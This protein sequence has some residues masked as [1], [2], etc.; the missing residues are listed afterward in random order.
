M[1]AWLQMLTAPRANAMMTENPDIKPQPVVAPIQK[2]A[3]PQ[4]KSYLPPGS[5]FAS[6]E[7]S[8]ANQTK[9]NIANGTGVYSQMAKQQA[10]VGQSLGMTKIPDPVVQPTPTNQPP[11]D[12][13]LSVSE[14]TSIPSGGMMSSPKNYQQQI[15]AALMKSM[16]KQQENADRAQ[17]EY[18]QVGEQPRGLA[19]VD[20]SP[21]LAMADQ[22]NGTNLSSVYKAP[23]GKTDH[24]KKKAALQAALEK[25]DGTVT[26]SQ[27]AYLKMKV[28]EE[29][30]RESAKMRMTL[31]GAKPSEFEKYQQQGMGKAAAEYFTQGRGQLE[32]NSQKIGDASNLIQEAINTKSPLFGA[33]RG[34]APDG[35]RAFTNP[36]AVEVKQAI[37]SAVTDTLKPTLG[38]QFTEG[39]GKRIMALQIDDRLSDEENLRRAVQLQGYIDRKI[40]FTDDLYAWAAKNNGDTS[41]FPFAKYGMR[42]TGGGAS[43]G[44][45]G[46][47]T[48]KT[49]APAKGSGPNGALSWEEYQQAKREGRL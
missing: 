19:Q 8:G 15:E 40:Q 31:A 33:I 21:M 46:Q 18:D 10:P 45:G 41:G 17:S 38:A 22:W 12:M 49:Q 16:E 28:D 36:R 13:S 20:W 42:K 7:E 23:T 2:P 32:N 30:S 24:E 26:A 3:P 25:A 48:G 44:F 1:S 4:R 35:I 11:R 5:L 14:S 37:Q 27:L 47:T 43:G 29:A 34:S 9:E 6:L 39:E